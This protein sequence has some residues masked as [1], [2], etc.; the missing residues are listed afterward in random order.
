MDYINNLESTEI[1]DNN[2]ASEIDAYDKYFTCSNSIDSNNGRVPGYS[3][4]VFLKWMMIPCAFIYLFFLFNTVRVSLWP[5]V[6]YGRPGLP[7]TLDTRGAYFDINMFY[8]NLK[9]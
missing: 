7:E 4:A 5:K 9:K 8:R 1:Y 6:L 3:Y 2:T